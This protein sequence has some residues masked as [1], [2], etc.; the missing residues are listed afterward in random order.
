M[1]EA[2]ILLTHAIGGEAP[3]ACCCSEQAEDL[4]G[5][6]EQGSPCGTCSSLSLGCSLRREGARA[7]MGMWLYRKINTVQDSGVRGRFDLLWRLCQESGCSPGEL[8]NTG[9]KI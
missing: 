1:P 2:E 9:F 8:R 7:C 5:V 4:S 6:D 3:W